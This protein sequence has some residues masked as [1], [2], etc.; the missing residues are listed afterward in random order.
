MGGDG[1]KNK[2]SASLVKR[3]SPSCDQG[4]L[5]LRTQLVHHSVFRRSA[6]HRENP[7]S[8]Q[9]R[10]SDSNP[11]G[12]RLEFISSFLPEFPQSFTGHKH[13]QILGFVAKGSFGPI[14]KVKDMSKDE[15]YAIKVLSK[16]EVL[17]NGVLQQSKEEV[18][19]QRQVRHP[20]LL[21]LRDCWQSQSNLFIMCDYC[22]TG[23]LYTYWS[24]KGRFDERDVRVFAAELGSA[25]G[26]LRLTDFGL[27][28][29][30]EHGDRAFTI[31][32][33]IQYMAPEVLSGGPYSHA[34]DWWSL[35][36]LLYAL[37]TGGF[38]LPAEADHSDMLTSVSE[39]PYDMPAS[40]SPALAFL[41]IE[42]LC[43][44]PTRRLR[45]LELFQSQKFFHGMSFD[46]QLLQKSPIEP[47]LELKNHPDRP[48]RSMRGLS[49][50]LVQN[51]ECDLQN[52]PS[53]PADL[54]P[55]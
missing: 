23:D 49:L 21:S 32:G 45:C 15:T 51:F 1:S 30:L 12:P 31:C 40:L 7:V 39:C 26:H 29:R 5:A 24:L 19:I 50:D 47:I 18:I 34:A 22:S 6:Q 53:N 13:L 48:E 14:L 8:E 42:L 46:S 54:S 33:T 37:A 9:S 28:R 3:R 20:F 10:P 17:S 25:L 4:F 44:I 35:G 52:S 16:A 36:I 43:K 38:P 27:S 55:T 11:E 41:L 2:D